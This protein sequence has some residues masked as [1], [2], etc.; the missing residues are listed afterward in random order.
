[1]SAR[2]S[3]YATWSQISLAVF[4]AICVSLH[5]GFVLKR[6]EG[7]FSNYGVHIKTAVPYSLGFGLC[8]LFAFKAARELRRGNASWRSLEVVL[9]VYGALMLLTLASTYGYSLNEPLKFL[10]TAIGITTM[11]FESVASVWMYS[12]IEGSNWDAALLVMA[13]GG[14]ALGVIDF[15]GILHV[16]FLVQL[17]IGVAFGFLLVHAVSRIGASNSSGLARAS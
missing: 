13:V 15:V 8:A 12:R 16:L 7:G 5:P 6:N 9:G 3:K 2:A 11:L 14:L 17:L 1:M 4:S 10:H